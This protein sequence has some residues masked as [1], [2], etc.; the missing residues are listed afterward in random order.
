MI[1]I[2]CTNLPTPKSEKK[3]SKSSHI[4]IDRF[5]DIDGDM[6]VSESMG[7]ALHHLAVGVP[8]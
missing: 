1:W 4:S 3:W 8:P 7:I 5:S 2:H 6:E